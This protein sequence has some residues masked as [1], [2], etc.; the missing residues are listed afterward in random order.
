MRLNLKFLSSAR[1]AGKPSDIPDPRFSDPHRFSLSIEQ[2]AIVASLFFSLSANTLFFSSALAGR[3]AASP[4]TWLFAVSVFVAITALHAAGLLVLL[5]RWTAKPLLAILFLVTAAAA[6]YMNKYTVFFNTEMVRNVLKTDVKEASELLS[7]GM[8]IH[9]LLFAVLPILVLWRIPLRYRPWKRAV[10]V[11]IAYIGGA[12]LLATGAIML[13]FQD[14]SSLMRNHKEVRFLIT[15]SNYL[16]SAAKVFS[17]DSSESGPRIPISADARLQASWGKRSKPMLFVLVVGE[18][19]RAANWGLNGYAHQTTP[20]LAQLD[21]LNFTRAQ[22]CGTNTEVSVPCMFSPYGRHNYDE[23][24]IR[25]HESVLHI[26]EHAGI[27]T[28]WRD[29][30]AGCKGV[31]DGLEQQRLDD[32][33]DAELC[34]GDRCLDEIML[35]GLDAEVHKAKNGNIFVVLHQLGNHGPAY[36]QR[37][38]ASLRRFVPTCDTSDLSKCSREQIVNSYDNAVLYT[39]HFLAKTIAFLKAEQKD[40][41]TAMWYMSDHG[42]SLGENGIYLH[43]LPYSIAPKEQTSIPMVMWFSNGFLSSFHLNR[44]CL[45][46]KTDSPVSHDNLFHT[47]LGMLQIDS[48]YYD[49]A[50]DLTADCRR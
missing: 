45:A 20:E 33:K 9:I 25:R 46:R 22:S 24:E 5:N 11:R 27:K 15:P 8:L 4:H 50:F 38:P 42:E 30:Q 48:K 26:I 32:S 43:G 6:Y 3:A 23:K 34:N 2:L 36:Y 47:V 49:K 44:D 18:T 1:R 29:N 13:V 7:L 16:I 12:L 35:K 17:A 40:Y 39:D 28:L 19:T 14:F 21:I 37:Y 31:C 41:N 10:M